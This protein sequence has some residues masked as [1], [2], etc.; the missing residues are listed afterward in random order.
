MPV[1]LGRSEMELFYI[2]REKS[3]SIVWIIDTEAGEVPSAENYTEYYSRI[4]Q[5][6]QAKDFEY[7]NILT[8][9][10]SSD[11]QQV[12]NIGTGTPFWIVDGQMGRVVVFENMPEDFEG[13][14]LPIENLMTVTGESHSYYSRQVEEEEN[15]AFE[16]RSEPKLRRGYFSYVTFGIIAVNIVVFLLTDLLG[17]RLGTRSWLNDGAVYWKYVFEKNEYYRLFTCMFLHADISHISSN[18]IVLYAVGDVLER[19]LGR[20][21]YA[22]LYLGGGILTSLA[23]STYYKMNNQLVMSIGAS[24]AIFALTGA[25]IIY[26]VTHRER[27]RYVNG[28]R[29]FIFIFYIG[30]SFLANANGGK[31]DNAAHICGFLVGGLIVLLMNIFEKKETR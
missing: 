9:F 18:M 25:L 20:V 6:F 12:K 28:S 16:K 19:E 14:R 5:S 8:L 29:I 17:K 13:I 2:G 11:P 15:G 21:K 31:V 27:I 1:D 3:A 10:L 22:I 7:I 4:K 24:G 30:Y 26:I 23:S